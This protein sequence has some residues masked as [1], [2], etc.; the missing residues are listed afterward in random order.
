[1]LARRMRYDDE[2]MAFDF[3]LYIKFS[4]PCMVPRGVVSTRR[5]HL[6]RS[7]DDLMMKQKL[8]DSCQRRGRIEKELVL[9][10][11]LSW[12]LCT[13]VYFAYEIYEVYD[14]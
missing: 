3:L 9:G 1:M 12:A 5:H 13:E 7:F 10:F 8:R 14:H 6:K 11:L 2:T 4:S